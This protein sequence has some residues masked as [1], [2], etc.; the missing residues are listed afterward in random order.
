MLSFSLEPYQLA[1]QEEIISFI[2]DNLNTPGHEDA[3]TKPFNRERWD[4]CGQILLQGLAIPK[5]YGGRGLS[6]VDTFLGLEALGYTNPDNGLSFS[7]SAHLLACTMPLLLYGSETLKQQYLTGLSNGKIIAANGM[8][9]PATGSD[10][11]AMTSTGLPISGGYKING[12]KTFVSNGPVSDAVMLYVATDLQRGFMGGITA[13]WIDRKLHPYTA[14]PPFEKAGMG[15]SALGSLF[16]HD[17]EV[18]EGYR[19]GQEG[20]GAHIFN[21]SMEW[22]RICLGACHLGNL[23]R[24]MEDIARLIR[25]DRHITASQ[26]VMHQLANIKAQYTAVRLQALAAAWKMDQGKPVGVDAA[27]A[28]LQISEL[29]KSA[30]SILS[31]SFEGLNRPNRD[32]ALSHMD[33]LSSTIYSGTSEMQRTIISQAL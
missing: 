30:T 31:T 9:E 11:F 10:A 3:R 21:R 20:R 16:F 26:S 25:M 2:R 18:D 27:M 8:T 13:F 1:L 15:S 4:T 33:A 6:A 32:A 17:L 14:S 23:Q 29:Y 19:V 28:K 5:E 24:L 12:S 22:E 7:I